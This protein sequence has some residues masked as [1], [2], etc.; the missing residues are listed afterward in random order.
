[1]ANFR[2]AARVAPVPVPPR[3]L[4]PQHAVSA[5]LHDSRAVPANANFVYHA[6]DAIS[7]LIPIPHR[8][9]NIGGEGVARGVPDARSVRA[10]QPCPHD[11]EV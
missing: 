6:H 1:M 7:I 8:V 11:C 2:R 4:H 3:G 10:Q 5:T 9:F